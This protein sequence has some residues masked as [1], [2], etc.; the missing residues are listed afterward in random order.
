MNAIDDQIANSDGEV[1]GLEDKIQVN[2]DCVDETTGFIDE[3]DG[4]EGRIAK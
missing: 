3:L 2:S 1:S 4:S